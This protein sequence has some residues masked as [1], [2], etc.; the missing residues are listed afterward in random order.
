VRRS[1]VVVCSTL[2]DLQRSVLRKKLDLKKRG[3]IL[4]EVNLCALIRVR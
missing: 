3:N 2:L 4:E 1:I